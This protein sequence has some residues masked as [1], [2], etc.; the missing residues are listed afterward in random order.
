MK[1]ADCQPMDELFAHADDAIGIAMV[2]NVTRLNAWIEANKAALPLH[3]VPVDFDIVRAWE[4]AGIIDTERADSLPPV[5]V[6]TMPII[7]LELPPAEDG[8]IRHLIADGRHRY[9]HRA[10]EQFET[11]IA[12]ILMPLQWGPFVIEDPPHTLTEAEV[13]NTRGKPRNIQ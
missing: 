13:L 2:I 1:W 3:H 5:V 10:Y 8:E 6:R 4:R 7:V 11:A 9:S 12:Y